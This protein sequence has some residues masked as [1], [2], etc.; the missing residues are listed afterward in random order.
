MKKLRVQ[1]SNAQ[2]IELLTLAGWHQFIS[3]GANVAGVARE[4]GTERFPAAQ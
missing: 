4:N 1:W 3:L 2:L